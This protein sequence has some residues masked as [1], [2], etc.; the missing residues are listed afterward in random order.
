MALLGVFYSFA[1]SGGTLVNRCLGAVKGNLVLSEVNPHGAL[2][3]VEVQ[4][5]DWLGLVSP[6]EFDALA[7]QGYGAKIRRLAELAAARREC[8]IIRDWTTLNFLRGLHFEYSDPSFLLEQEIYLAHHGLAAREAVI[9]RRAAAVYESITRTFDH[10]RELR[11]QDFGTAYAAYAQAV[12]GRPVFQFERFCADPPRELRRLCEVIGAAYA[13]SFLSD[14]STFDRCT[15]DNQL[16]SRSRARRADRIVALPDNRDS[17]AW[18]AAAADPQCRVADK[19]FG[20][21]D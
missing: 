5:R 18:R 21:A 6:H 9:A 2:V 7:E 12:A 15:G 20:Y 1:R 10:F 16:A 3:P 11:V 14:F 13:D 4:A 17:P 8:L 19:I